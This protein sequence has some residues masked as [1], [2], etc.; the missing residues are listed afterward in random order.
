MQPVN[1]FLLVMTLSVCILLN[2]PVVSV[3]NGLS[4]YAAEQ[5][6]NY[7]LHRWI[8]RCGAPGATALAI[9]AILAINLIIRA[10]SIIKTSF[11]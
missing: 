8:T 4:R 3:S 7:F 5:N 11:A 9:L 6:P 2:L 10:L 1:I